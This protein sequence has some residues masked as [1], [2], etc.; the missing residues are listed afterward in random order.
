[1][2]KHTERYR[3]LFFEGHVFYEDEEMPLTGETLLAHY[4]EAGDALPKKLEG[5]F[6]FVIHDLKNDRYFASRDILGIKPLYY[7]KTASGFHFATDIGEL[8]A[9]PGVEK[10]PNIL[11]MKTMLFHNT[12][13]FDETMYQG[14]HRVP[15]SHYVVVEK[16]NMRKQRYWFPEQIKKNYTISEEDA[17]ARVKELLER[18][19]LRAAPSLE[20]TAFE[21]SG[22]LD[23]SSIVSLLAKKFDPSS[24]DCYSQS[25]DGMDCD[26]GEYTDSL[27][28][29]YGLNIRKVDAAALDYERKYSLENLYT[30]A[31]YWPITLSFAIGLPEY[32]QAAKDGKRVIVT[33]QGGDHLFQGSTSVYLDLLRRGRLVMLAQELKEAK[34]PWRIV[35]NTILKPLLGSDLVNLIRKWK[36]STTSSD[37][38]DNDSLDGNINSMVKAGSSSQ[39]KAI[40]TLLSAFSSTLF[41]CGIFH[42]AESNFGLEMRHP[43]FDK[44]LIEFIL[45][46]PPEM[47]YQRQHTKWILRTAMQDVLPDKIR[48]RNNKAEFSSPIRKQLETIDI[49]TLSS[50]RWLVRLGILNDNVFDYYIGQDIKKAG[51]ITI[52]RLWRIINIEYWY[53]R[54]WP[55]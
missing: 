42:P 8:L 55:H 4:A 46:L 2:H 53:T 44:R 12:V 24:I 3:L 11:S 45:T 22:G 27:V 17:A 25:F 10:Q 18:S 51:I 5:D 37:P 7:V 26:E 13:A 28:E 52:A 6:S 1:M 21:V 48:D 35:R 30:I 38:F 9:L 34:K 43:F 49:V 40:D 20:K 41:D 54:H 14:I 16:G 19:I 23:S 33:G 47:F 39:Q 32:E 50:S 15:P 36:G 31:P 29:K